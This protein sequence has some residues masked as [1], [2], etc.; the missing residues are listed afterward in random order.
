MVPTSKTS[1][2]AAEHPIIGIRRGICAQI[3]IGKDMLKLPCPNPPETEPCSR[4]FPEVSVEDPERAA[5]EN[6]WHFLGISKGKTV[7]CGPD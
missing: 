3:P 7:I 1:Q 4:D 5:G 2:I 6:F